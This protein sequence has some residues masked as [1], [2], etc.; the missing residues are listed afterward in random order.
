MELKIDFTDKEITPWGGI[1]LMHQFLK[2]FTKSI[3]A[4]LLDWDMVW[5]KLFRTLRSYPSR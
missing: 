4:A 5:G 3:V 2:I 1:S